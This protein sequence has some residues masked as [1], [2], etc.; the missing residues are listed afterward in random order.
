MI[1]LLAFVKSLYSL[2]GLVF[3]IF[4]LG[5][6]SFGGS[7]SPLSSSST[8]TDDKCLPTFFPFFLV[9]GYSSRLS[10]WSFFFSNFTSPSDH[11]SACTSLLSWSDPFF[12]FFPPFSISQFTRFTQNFH[13]MFRKT[14]PKWA[15]KFYKFYSK[16]VENQR[17]D[18]GS[19]CSRSVEQNMCP[20]LRGPK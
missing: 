13:P 10:A 20:K 1:W 5:I 4:V 3:L 18:V 8:I 7:H 6:A 9:G 17:Y 15:R 14:S 12:Y 16:F 11:Q 2:V 19:R